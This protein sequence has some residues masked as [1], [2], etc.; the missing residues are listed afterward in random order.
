MRAMQG[1]C[2]ESKTKNKELT[3]LLL[4]GDQPRGST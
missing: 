3:L 4:T 2:P 1:S